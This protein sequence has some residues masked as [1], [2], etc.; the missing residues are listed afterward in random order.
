MTVEFKSLLIKKA[1]VRSLNLADNMIGNI[2][3]V[4]PL[5]LTLAADDVVSFKT[6]LD[7]CGIAC[8]DYVFKCDEWGEEWLDL[9]TLANRAESWQCLMAIVILFSRE[10]ADLRVAEALANARLAMEYPND[11]TPP[12][13]A[14]AVPAIYCGVLKNHILLGDA[15]MLPYLS[16]HFP[17]SSQLMCEIFNLEIESWTDDKE[18]SSFLSHWKRMVEAI[19]FDDDASFDAALRNLAK[20]VARSGRDPRGWLGADAVVFM[21]KSLTTFGSYKCHEKFWQLMNTFL[22]RKDL[23]TSTALAYAVAISNEHVDDLSPNAA[24]LK[25]AVE[26]IFNSLLSDVEDEDRAMVLE[27]VEKDVWTKKIVDNAISKSRADK[28]HDTLE[29]CTFDP[30]TSSIGTRASSGMRI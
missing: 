14:K 22:T 10:G 15:V 19:Q 25:L 24:T 27:Y 29:E 2:E 6:L 16:W 30:N 17:D 9:M 3:G 18:V 23:R 28:L 20:E 26:G 13:L 7:N 11:Q 1:K 12:H 21:C 5:L 8:S 4:W